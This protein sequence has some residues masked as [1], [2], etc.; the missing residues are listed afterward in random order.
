MSTNDP[1]ARFGE[2]PQ[3][4]LTSSVMIDGGPLAADRKS[5]V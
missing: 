4:S 2:V 1:F 5:V 3:F